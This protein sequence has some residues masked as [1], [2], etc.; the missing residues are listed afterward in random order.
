MREY[1][2]LFGF[3]LIRVKFSCELELSLEVWSL[4]QNNSNYIL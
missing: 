4:A 3:H 2:L 1:F